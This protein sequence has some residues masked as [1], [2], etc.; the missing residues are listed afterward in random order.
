MS[1]RIRHR[2]PDDYGEFVD[3]CVSLFSNR[4]S[5]IDLAGGHQPIFNEDEK[6][7]I[8]FNGEIYNFPELKQTLEQKGHRFKTKTDT[9]VIL[10]GYEEYG[11]EIFSMLDGM[12][13]VAIWNIRERRLI[14][15]RDRAGIKPLYFAKA[16]SG[17]FVFCSEIKGILANL[18]VPISVNEE[19]LYDLISLYY[20]PFERTLFSGIFKLNPGH[21]YDTKTGT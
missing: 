3:Q 13:A 16:P 5:I 15:A 12:F 20:I 8:V 4:L 21:Y 18:D 1:E 9:E 11:T 19:G 6:L 17:D 10:H 2:G 14:L 7:L